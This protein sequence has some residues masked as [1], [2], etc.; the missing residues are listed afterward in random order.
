MQAQT[1]QEFLKLLSKGVNPGDTTVQGLLKVTTQQ[2]KRAGTIQLRPDAICLEND[3]TTVLEADL[4]KR[5]NDRE[6]SLAAEVSAIGRVLNDGTVFRRVVILCKTERIR[7]RAVA[8]LEGLVEA[9]N[10]EVLIPG[11]RHFLASEPGT[12]AVWAALESKLRDGRTELV[13]TLVGHVIIQLLPIWLPKVR[14][15]ASNTH[16]IAGW[17]GENYL[18][19]KRPDSLG[20][21]KV[22]ISPLAAYQG[23]TE[24]DVAHSAGA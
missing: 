21:W 23:T 14:I 20:S 7:K 3:G 1:E 24:L 10:H 17:F 11:R 2:G 9:N 13:D 15:D 16:S 19:Y 18:P 12:Y 6:A 5:G 8:V 4:S 22:L